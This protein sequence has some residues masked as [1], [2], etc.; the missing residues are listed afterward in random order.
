VPRSRADLS[1]SVVAM[2][3]THADKSAEVR[4]QFIDNLRY[5]VS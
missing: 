3:T 4:A 5:R 1:A 2:T